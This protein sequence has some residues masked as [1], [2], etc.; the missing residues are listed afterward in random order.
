MLT[1]GMN[2]DLFRIGDTL[3]H[4]YSAMRQ[5]DRDTKTEH[6]QSLIGS[7]CGYSSVFQIDCPK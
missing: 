7:R 6:L 4:S 5:T 2:Y 3:L 1:L